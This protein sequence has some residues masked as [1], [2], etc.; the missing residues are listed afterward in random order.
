MNQLADLQK[1][2]RPANFLLFDQCGNN[3]SG[4]RRDRLGAVLRLDAVKFDLVA[5][6]ET[7]DLHPKLHSVVLG[8]ASIFKGKKPFFHLRI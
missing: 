7:S 8:F 3:R 6:H 5:F 4:S 2:R 1:N